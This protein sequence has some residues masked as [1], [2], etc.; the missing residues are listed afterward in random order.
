MSSEV[1]TSR[2]AT[3]AVS[4]RDS[5]T[6]LGMTKIALIQMGC[7]AEPE[8][9]FSRAIEFIRDAARKGAQIACLPELFR[10]QYFCQAEDHK[11]FDLAEE[12]PGESTAA[13]GGIARASGKMFIAFICEMR[14]AV[15]DDNTAAV[16]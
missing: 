2:G 5:S 14:S 9:N 10:S 1:E 6:P 8:K 13:L 7:G 3:S 4:Q 12:V 15:L 16:I 11:N